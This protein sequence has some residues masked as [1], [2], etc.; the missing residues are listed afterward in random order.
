MP[1]FPFFFVC[2]EKASTHEEKWGKEDMV[3]E[4][5][6]FWFFLFLCDGKFFVRKIFI[7]K[8]E[9]GWRL[10]FHCYIFSSICIYLFIFPYKQFSRKLHRLDKR[11]EERMKSE[12]SEIYYLKKAE[13][14]SQLVFFG[15][16]EV[17]VWVIDSLDI[18]NNDNN[19]NNTFFWHFDGKSDRDARNYWRE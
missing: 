8:R 12:T 4:H 9:G 7:C 1:T 10:S 6:K 19:N 18:W 13:S 2:L 11:N 15:C 14:E 5:E 3:L 17:R 16:V